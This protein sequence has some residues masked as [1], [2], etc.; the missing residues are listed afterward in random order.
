[1]KSLKYL[2]ILY[3]TRFHKVVSFSLR[4]S[5]NL[6]LRDKDESNPLKPHK[7]NLG[8]TH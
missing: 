8:K 7:K 6:Y 4:N 2:N 1:M 5:D 3:E